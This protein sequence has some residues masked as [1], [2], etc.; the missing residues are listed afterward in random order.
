MV[1]LLIKP[2]YKKW[3][4]ILILIFITL[5]L[6]LVI[7]FAFAIANEIKKYKSSTPEQKLFNNIVYTQQRQKEVEGENNPWF[8][9]TD[10]KVT[11]VEFVDYSCSMCKNS[12]STIREISLIY[13]NN[14]KIIIRDFPGYEQSLNLA[15]AAHCA[16]EQGLF[17]QMHDKLFQ[18]QGVNQREQLIELANQIGADL[19]R[20][21]D[22]FDQQ[23]YLKQI[24]ENFSAGQ[25]LG[26]TGT[27]T[28]F[29]NGVKIEGD[30]PYELFIQIMEELIQN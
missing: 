26:V 4:G 29:I 12:Y 17:W 9:S 24:Q 7:A 19:T 11:I 20:F 14:V 23:K 16:K 8:G 18:N 30:I 25:N 27:P 6:I 28:W 15:M 2:W 3:W 10:P 21:T 1:N 22:C 5:I 13:Q